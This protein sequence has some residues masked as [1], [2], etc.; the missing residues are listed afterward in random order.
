MQRERVSSARKGGE[1]RARKWWFVVLVG[2]FVSA[3]STLGQTCLDAVALEPCRL[4]AST[5]DVVAELLG[6]VSNA[7]GMISETDPRPVF[8]YGAFGRSLA[9]RAVVIRVEARSVVDATRLEQIFSDAV[10]LVGTVMGTLLADQSLA[11]Q[12]VSSETPSKS[13][14]YFLLTSSEIRSGARAVFHAY[15]TDQEAAISV[16]T[17][18]ASALYAAVPGDRDSVGAGYIPGLGIYAEVTIFRYGEDAGAPELSCSDWEAVFTS[19][20]QSLAALVLPAL[21]ADEALFISTGWQDVTA[22]LYPD[23][24]ERFFFVASA[25]TPEDSL[26]W[27]IYRQE[28]E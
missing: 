13:I 4:F 17:P 23:D 3:V 7:L 6:S 15:R 10:R 9:E 28:R 16:L 21:G 26:T 11:I 14:G 5:A 8:E 27:S 25:W 22:T 20:V 12:V 1:M 18:L 2:L 19:S 24:E